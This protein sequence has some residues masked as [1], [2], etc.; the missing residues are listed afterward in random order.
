MFTPQDFQS[1]SGNFTTLCMKGLSETL[2]STFNQVRDKMNVY[3]SKRYHNIY[4][5][6]FKKKST[7]EI[8]V[9]YLSVRLLWPHPL[10]LDT[11]TTANNLAERIL[12]VTMVDFFKICLHHLS[13]TMTHP[14]L[15]LTIF[16]MCLFL[17]AKK[18]PVAQLLC[19]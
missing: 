13:S 7:K 18:K 17:T 11:R 5:L 6:Y 19:T 9:R 3:I 15:P 12:Y 8:D 2:C 14:A 4:F 1:M 10:W 16:C